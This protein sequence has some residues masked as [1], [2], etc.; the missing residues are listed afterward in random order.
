MGTVNVR[1][2]SVH[3][4]ARGV[5]AAGQDWG[6]STATLAA[7]MGAVGNPYGG[8]ELGNAL[9]DMYEIIGPTALEY[10]EQTG[11][12]LV[13]TAAALNQAATAYTRIEQD[14]TTQMRRVQA[15]MDSLGDV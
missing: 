5:D 4:A 9:K 10:L 12:C 6:E 2:E 11:F 14:N 15:I 8:D 3:G 1:P 7:D 13:E